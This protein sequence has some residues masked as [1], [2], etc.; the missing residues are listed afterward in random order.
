MKL[1][2]LRL[3]KYISQADLAKESGVSEATIN[4][5]EKGLHKPSFKTIRDLAKA[6]G[7][8]PGDIEF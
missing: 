2:E 6:L 3:K 4:R 7:V 1:K 8:E 5:L